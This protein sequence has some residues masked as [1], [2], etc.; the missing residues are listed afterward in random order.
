MSS[1]RVTIIVKIVPPPITLLHNILKNIINI[2]GT[3]IVCLA[4]A[5]N[6]KT[7]PKGGLQTA[8]FAKIGQPLPRN[9]RDEQIA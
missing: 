8:G 1:L 3:L 4:F 2:Y 7:G 5:G 6:H 9:H